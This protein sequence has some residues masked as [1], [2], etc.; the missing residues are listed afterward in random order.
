MLHNTLQ[1]MTLWAGRL[2]WSKLPKE[3]EGTIAKSDLEGR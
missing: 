2:S 3:V 1:S